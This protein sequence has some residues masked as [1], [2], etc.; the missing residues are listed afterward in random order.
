MRFQK[1][2]D[3]YALEWGLTIWSWR[4]KGS[5]TWTWGVSLTK[6]RKG[7]H[8][9]FDRQ[10]VALFTHGVYLRAYD[11]VFRIERQKAHYPEQSK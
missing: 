7:A 1:Y 8:E 5:L 3:D 6:W 9:G 10:I 11:Y 4:P 2:P